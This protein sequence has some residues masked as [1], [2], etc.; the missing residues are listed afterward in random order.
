MS[1]IADCL[2]HR[3]AQPLFGIGTITGAP[4]VERVAKIHLIKDRLCTDRCQLGC[5]GLNVSARECSFERV[6][7]R[8][9]RAR[10]QRNARARDV[11]DVVTAGSQQ[12]SKL[13]QALAQACLGMGFKS[14]EP[15][16]PAQERTIK[17]FA[18][19]KTQH[20]QQRPRTAVGDY[21][22]IAIRCDQSEAPEQRA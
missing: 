21:N 5:R 13:E 2:L 14:T 6:Q 12:L 11:E 7:I 22:F 20:R 19:R 1:Q 15:Q 18:I 9:N 17:R 16:Q 8:R 10:S 3:A 4:L